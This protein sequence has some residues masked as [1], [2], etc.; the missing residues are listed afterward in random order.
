MSLATWSLACGFNQCDSARGRRFQAQRQVPEAQEAGL[1]RGGFRPRSSLRRREWAWARG[2]TKR[3][4]TWCRLPGARQLGQGA[5]TLDFLGRPVLVV[6]PTSIHFCRFW[7][8]TIFE[9]IFAAEFPCYL[10]R[11]LRE[12]SLGERRCSLQSTTGSGGPWRWPCGRL[13][14]EKRSMLLGPRHSARK[15]NW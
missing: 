6:G 1:A 9:S 14:R 10:P 12:H 7:C 2:V 11:E 8:L 3:A 4:W 5:V 13:W 15:M